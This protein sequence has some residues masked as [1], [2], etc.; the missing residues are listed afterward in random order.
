M[1]EKKA[2]RL[3]D[4]FC[5]NMSKEDARLLREAIETLVAPPAPESSEYSETPAVVRHYLEYRTPPP[6][7]EW[8]WAAIR[9]AS[10]E[11]AFRTLLLVEMLDVAMTRRPEPTEG[12]QG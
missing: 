12:E 8:D 7:C 2:R 6:G 3:I 10:L 4:V 1:T 9:T 5:G 11:G